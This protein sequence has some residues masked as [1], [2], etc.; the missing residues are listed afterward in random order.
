MGDALGSA[1]VNNI[2]VP[3]GYKDNPIDRNAA[4]IRLEQSLDRML[5][6][7]HPK[8][9]LL[10]AVESKLFG[11]GVE[12]C[13]I[14]SHE[15]YLG[16]AIRNKILLCLDM[17]HFHPTENIADK[18]SSVALSVDEILLH[19]SRPMRWDSDHVILL[20][21]DI[22]SMAQE[23][24]SANLLGRTHIGLD[25]FDATISRTAAWVIGTRNMQKA[26]L[27][28][29]LMPIVTLKESEAKLDFTTRLVLTEELKDLPFASVWAEFCKR[30]D[31]AQG[32]HLLKE[33]DHYQSKV[34]V[35]E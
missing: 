5:A 13:T 14:G 31:V 27:H 20:N 33:L 23:L 24:V 28:A 7:P 11:I 26:L 3:D 8:S 2:W 32:K 30:T 4:R 25:F 35:R 6:Q 16:Y 19:V 21:D 17:G 9:N 22:L 29:L 10:D 15:F 1:A 18:L 34:G 12:A